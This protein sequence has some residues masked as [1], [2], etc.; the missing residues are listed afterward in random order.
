[1]KTPQISE[2]KRFQYKTLYPFN[3]FIKYKHIIKTFGC[4]KTQEIH[5]PYTLIERHYLR[6]SS[7]P[8]LNSKLLKRMK[9]DTK[10]NG[11]RERL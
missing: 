7:L 8:K 5:C 2:G 1:M 3:P 10:N 9:L 11:G 6:D 4:A